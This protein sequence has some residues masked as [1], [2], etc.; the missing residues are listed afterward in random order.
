M[1]VKT[2]QECRKRPAR[3]LRL[4]ESIERLNSAMARMTQ[5]LSHAPAGGG[6]PG[7][8]LAEQIDLLIDLTA[9]YAKRTVELETIRAEVTAW[10]DTLPEQQANIIYHRYVEGLS[11]RQVA[12]ATNYSEQHC[13]RIH[14]AALKKCV[15]DKDE[16]K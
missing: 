10:L 9:A 15:G 3:V 16:S 12:K 5:I 7:D 11:W 2:L 14:E 1:T 13:F 8:K 6:V 4:E